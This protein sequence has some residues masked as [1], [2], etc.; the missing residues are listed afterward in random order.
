MSL[1]QRLGRIGL[2]CATFGREIDGDAAF[3]LMDHAVAR[4]ITHFD[5]AAAYSAGRSETIVGA[6]AASRRP[7][8]GA[9]LIATKIKPPFTAQD[10]PRAITASRERLGGAPIDLLYLH[11]WDDGLLNFE[12]LAALDSAVRAGDVG[13]IGASNF[14]ASQLNS[15]LSRQK[16]Q[17]FA[18]L[19]ALQNNHNFAV[20]DVDAATIETCARAGLAIVT[21]SPLGAGFLTGKHRAGVAA[22][23]R[24]DIVPGHQKVYFN[25]LAWER[26]AKLEAISQRTGIPPALMALAWALNQPAPRTVLVGGRGPSQIDQ[27]LDATALGRPAWLDELNEA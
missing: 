22:G 17:G 25:A 20:R 7:P 24:F 9:L 1:S 14:N 16:Q 5:T 6:W 26:L 23:S 10:I 11:Q 8:A 13:A 19:Q 27:A 2:G 4:G 18:S 21:Y 12:T 15:V 3:A